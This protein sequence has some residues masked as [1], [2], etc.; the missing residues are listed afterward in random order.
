MRARYDMLAG[1][2]LPG[3]FE[4]KM[5]NARPENTYLCNETHYRA[6]KAVE[7]GGPRAAYFLHI[8]YA[9]EGT[10]DDHVELAAAVATL[11]TAIVRLA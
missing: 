4:L 2:A 5:A 8:P 6:L 11:L 10:K 3:G 7:A 1:T 9:R